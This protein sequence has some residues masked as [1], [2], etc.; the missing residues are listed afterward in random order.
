MYER[1]RIIVISQRWIE[2]GRWLALAISWPSEVRKVRSLQTRRHWVLWIDK[3]MNCPITSLITL[4]SIQLFEQVVNIWKRGGARTR[5][6]WGFRRANSQNKL[7]VDETTEGSGSSSF[8]FSRGRQYGKASGY[9]LMTLNNASTTRFRIVALEWFS[10]ALS[11]WVK[12]LA[13]SGV[14]NWES[15]AR[16]SAVSVGNE[17]RSL[18]VWC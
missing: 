14:T 17:E 12:S 7:T 3:G 6:S 18:R 5:K 1:I 15:P 16:A 11:S 4:M 2:W 10:I 9:C 13:R 8:S